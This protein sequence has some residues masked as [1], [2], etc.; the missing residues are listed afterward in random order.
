MQVIV[1]CFNIFFQI[2]ICILVQGLYYNNTVDVWNTGCVEPIYEFY[3]ANAEFVLAPII[4]TVSIFELIFLSKALC[5]GD[6]SV[7]AKDLK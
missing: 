4:I 5:H 7:S 3:Q 1:S 2:F 6:T